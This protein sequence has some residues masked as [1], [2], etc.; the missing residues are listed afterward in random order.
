MADSA[1]AWPEPHRAQAPRIST[2]I[3]LASMLASYT[4]VCSDIASGT[5]RAGLRWTGRETPFEHGS[6][7]R[8]G[9]TFARSPSSRRR[10]LGARRLS[11]CCAL[12]LRGHRVRFGASVARSAA[13][14][15]ALHHHRPANAGMTASNAGDAAPATAMRCRCLMTAFP[16]EA[17][18][19][20]ATAQR[21]RLLPQQP[22]A[23]RRLALFTNAAACEPAAGLM[24]SAQS[25]AKTVSDTPSARQQTSCDSP[26]HRFLAHSISAS[27]IP[28]CARSWC[29][30]MVLWWRPSLSS[31]NRPPIRN[32]AI[33]CRN[34]CM[35]ATC[36]ST[37]LRCLPCRYFVVLSR[38]KRRRRVQ[39]C[40]LFDSAWNKLQT[41]AYSR[42][43][44]GF[45]PSLRN[46]WG[47]PWASMI[48]ISYSTISGM[49]SWH[50]T[51]FCAGRFS[52]QTIYNL[53]TT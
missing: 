43:Q 14:P 3:I 42:G 5:Y 18:R 40:L 31:N 4:L 30:S 41:Y 37:G 12:M 35:P 19:N 28:P 24:L 2:R 26:G 49:Y 20:R 6:Q 34:A 11:T 27:R 13:L 17:L 25:A 36:I 21:R 1:R 50:N 46:Y 45:Q 52:V 22:S 44:G 15:T 51:D 39:P 38:D 7:C 32:D 9:T 8:S 16:E 23:P 33:R 47:Y 48:M 53:R 10:R 29:R